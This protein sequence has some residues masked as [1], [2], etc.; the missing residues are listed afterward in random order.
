MNARPTVLV[1]ITA[2]VVASVAV[3]AQ[4]VNHDLTAP[5]PRLPDGRQDYSGIWNVGN[6]TYFHDLGKGL[7]PGEIPRRT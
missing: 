6:M 1:T 3:H 4:W 5:A 2:L 7:K